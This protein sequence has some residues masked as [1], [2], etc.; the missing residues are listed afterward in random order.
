MRLTFPLSKLTTLYHFKPPLEGAFFMRACQTKV[1]KQFAH[2]GHYN[3]RGYKLV[4]HLI[5]NLVKPKKLQ[6][7][8][9]FLL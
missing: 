5:Y 8:V 4:Q 3:S 9:Y 1:T 2:P 6:C 7:C